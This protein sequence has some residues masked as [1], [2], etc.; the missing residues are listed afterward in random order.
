MVSLLLASVLVAGI[1]ILSCTVFYG[2]IE[3]RLVNPVLTEALI[4][5]AA[6]DA[7]A[8][9]G[10]VSDLWERFAFLLN[11][12]ALRRSLFPDADY[13]PSHTAGIFLMSIPGLQS[14][15]FV[16]SDGV[17]VYF[18]TNPEDIVISDTV[19]YRNYRDDPA[20][21]PFSEVFVAAQEP[22]KL[23]LDDA[24]NRVICAFPLFDSFD[25]HRGVALFSI[26]AETLAE[27]FAAAG[28]MGAGER[29]ALVANPGGFVCV[30]PE[31]NPGPA[32][33]QEILGEVSAAWTR[34]Y[35]SVVP[36]ISADARPVLVSVRMEHGCYFG[37][38]SGETALVVP[39][40]AR[41]L[42]L[43]TIFITLFLILFFLLAIRRPYVKGQLGA[44]RMVAA[45]PH[46]VI[47]EQN[48]IHY[49]NSDAVSNKEPEEKINS[50][51][52]KLVES[53]TAKP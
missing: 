7:K 35:R 18:S 43:V 24:H 41:L 1:I 51:F 28:R 42:V 31:A 39:Q 36:L 6:S 5:G 34:G 52:A 44:G 13:P 16:D 4:R 50:D 26:A 2:L 11:N 38:V 47:V 48:G 46:D 12:K 14:A 25:V 8:L 40:S 20:N 22:A 33:S 53:V 27:S 49:I 45:S 29:L 17:H 9:D 19:S 30:M 3:S 10:M 15:R 32:V 37:R 21:L 23:V